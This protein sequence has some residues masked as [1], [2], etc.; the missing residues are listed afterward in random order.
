MRGE[1]RP[2]VVSVREAAERSTQVHWRR[3]IDRGK[4]VGRLAHPAGPG[5]LVRTRVNALRRGRHHRQARSPLSQLPNL[6]RCI[7]S[8]NAQFRVERFGQGIHKDVSLISLAEPADWHCGRQAMRRE[9]VANAPC[10]MLRICLRG[11][12]FLRGRGRRIAKDGSRS[13]TY[14]CLYQL[15]CSSATTCSHCSAQC[16]R[17]D[18]AMRCPWCASIDRKMAFRRSAAPDDLS[19]MCSK[20]SW[21]STMRRFRNQ[22]SE[23][24][25]LS[26]DGYFAA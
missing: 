23:R 5:L 9:V 19:A 20:P 16:W 11:S 8:P 1:F 12:G 10:R 2:S 24:E 14:F 26:I 21:C 25:S 17:C 6:S 15:H 22:S 3:T 4:A 18:S 7:R 13:S